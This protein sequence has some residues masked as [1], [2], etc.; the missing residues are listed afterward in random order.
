MAVGRDRTIIAFRHGSGPTDL[1]T[2]GFRRN[3]RLA[4]IVD[5]PDGARMLTV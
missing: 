2:R 1:P 3:P 5:V 4:P